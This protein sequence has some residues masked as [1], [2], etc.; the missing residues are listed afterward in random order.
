[1]SGMGDS[2]K[3]GRGRGIALPGTLRRNSVNLYLSQAGGRE[4]ASLSLT[5]AA[6]PQIHVFRLSWNELM[7]FPS[8]SMD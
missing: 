6:M 8:V 2:Q 5:L 1:M 7:S 4:T 3:S